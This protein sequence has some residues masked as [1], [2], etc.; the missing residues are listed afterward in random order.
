MKT[1]SAYFVLL[2]LAALMASCDR[3]ETSQDTRVED[4]KLYNLDVKKIKK[5]SDYFALIGNH[6]VIFLDAS[7]ERKF[8]LDTQNIVTKGTFKF[9][10][11]DVVSLPNND[12]YVI[13]TELLYDKRFRLYLIRLNQKGDPVWD[14]PKITTITNT[15]QFDSTESST[16]KNLL[17]SFEENGYALAT[18]IKNEIIA[19]VNYKT[20]NNVPWRYGIISFSDKGD[21]ILHRDYTANTS[22]VLW[23][24]Y[25]DILPD[26]TITIVQ[27]NDTYLDIKLFNPDNFEPVGHIHRINEKLNYIMFTNMLPWSSDEVIFTGHANRGANAFFLE[28]FDVFCIKYNFRNNTIT[29]SL[30]SGRLKNDEFC[31]Q[32][33]LDYDNSIHCVGARRGDLLSNHTSQSSLLE[34]VFNLESHIQ[35]SVEIIQNLGYEGLYAEP[36]DITSSRQKILG[37]KLDISG[38]ENKQGFFMKVKTP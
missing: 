34:V 38:K 19:V 10:F 18:H 8:S 17:F 1:R 21:T 9:R 35:D 28:N 25:I 20:F 36:S 5:V 6:E 3:I 15:F 32:S 2:F 26:N 37:Y 29:D 27:G 16:E 30:F 22:H 11:T 4:L 24:Y 7:G 31:Y 12:I 33:Y 13:G 14:K 23:T